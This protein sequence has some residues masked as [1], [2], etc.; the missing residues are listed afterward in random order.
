MKIFIDTNIPMYAGGK[1]HPLKAGCID[2]LNSVARGEIEACT[3]SEVFQEILYRY[4]NIKQREIG[5]QI[6]DLFSQ[7]M[8]GSVL[9]VRHED[10]IK[11]R[12]LS[13]N[14]TGANLSPRDLIHLAVMLNYDIRRIIT[15][16]QGFNNVRGIEVIY[17]L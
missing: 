7:I 6:F 17:P 13:N 3:D 5:L 15:T 14:E 8:N 10:V 16:D 1:E 9:P 12:L 4:F 11:A 2:I